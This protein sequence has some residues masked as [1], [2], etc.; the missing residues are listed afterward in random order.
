[1]GESARYA[2]DDRIRHPGSDDHFLAWFADHKGTPKDAVDRLDAAV[3]SALANP[4][5]QQRLAELGQ[6]IFPV[7]QQNPAAL[8]AY[9]KAEVD[10]WWPVIK[11]VGIKAE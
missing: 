9:H 3:L 11:G 8:A 7:S 5:L 6:V 10:K 4:S 1:M 2:D